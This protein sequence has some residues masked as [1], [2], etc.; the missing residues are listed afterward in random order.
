MSKLDPKAVEIPLH[1]HN[2]KLLEKKR[3]LLTGSAIYFVKGPNRTGKTTFLNALAAMQLAKDDTPEPV[4]RGKD[5]G[6]NIF[7]IPGADGKVYTVRH[8]FNNKTHKFTAID[9]EGNKISSVNAIRE[10]FKY[11]HFTVDEFF[12]MSNTAEGRRKQKAIILELLPQEAREKFQLLEDKESEAYD[13]RK[14]IGREV[15]GKEAILNAFNITEE[16]LEEVE[17]IKEWQKAIDTYEKFIEENE[18]TIVNLQQENNKLRED[19]SSLRKKISE[20]SGY[21]L[22]KDEYDVAS[23]SLIGIREKFN[24]AEADIEKYRI[25]KAKIITDADLPIKD[26][27]FENEFLTID[28]FQFKESQVCESDGV[29]LI[30]KLMSRVN[31]GTIQLIGDASAL[32][33]DRLEE[34]NQI[35]EEEGKIMFVD[36]VSREEQELEVVGYEEIRKKGRPPKRKDP[37]PENKKEPEED[38]IHDDEGRV[39]TPNDMPTPDST[40]P[41]PGSE[42]LLF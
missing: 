11:T 42:K 13:Q 34:L 29:I 6:E 7:E 24:K 23:K 5:E 36:E 33:L 3:F 27:S 35:A 32:D 40:G 22:R 4:T 19:Q 41:G 39:E 16:Q 21:Q 30:A 15:E 2:Y 8:S 38:P 9:D 26:I 18:K 20:I 25:N 12:R 14:E 10:I 17:K 37:E 1:F 31:P 28:G